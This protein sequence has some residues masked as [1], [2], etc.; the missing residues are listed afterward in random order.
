MIWL[1][2]LITIGLILILFA[3]ARVAE[4]ETIRPVHLPDDLERYLQD[5]EAR[6]PDIIPN[7][8]KTIIWA[9]PATKSK[10]QIAIV[11]LHGFSASRQET[12]PLCDNFAR[13][14]GANL[15]YTRL[16]GHGRG[17][18]AMGEGTV[19]DWLNDTVEAF[20]I[21]RR[22]GERVLLV[23]TSTGGTLAAWFMATYRPTDL[24]GCVLISPNFLPAHPAARVLLFPWTTGII[25]KLAGDTWKWEPANPQ[26]GLY[27][28]TT[29]PISAVF[30]MM[31]LV[32]LVRKA[33]MAAVT[34]PT[35]LFY[36]PQDRVV[37]AQASQK[38]FARLASPIK[39]KIAITNAQDP[40]QH[41]LAGDILSPQ[42]T[43]P[44]LQ[45]M[46]TFVNALLA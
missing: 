45:E 27:W 7:T 32:R 25:R 29:H 37:N 14:V 18:A 39:R 16:T 23:G 13:Q 10:T 35:L 19:N 30:T 40:A 43:G 4:D 31:R 26:H 2:S 12:V 36:S 34:T 22:L 38:V 1:I 24:L 41:V 21:G 11:Y 5:A 44:I 3:F 46:L 9:Y 8:E 42:A 33:N 15:F 20:E 17:S 28:T 6:Y